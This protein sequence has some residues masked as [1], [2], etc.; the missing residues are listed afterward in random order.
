MR[1]TPRRVDDPPPRRA[2]TAKPVLIPRVMLSRGVFVGAIVFIGLG[3]FVLYSMLRALRA[4]R[5]LVAASHASSVRFV[6]LAMELQAELDER[7]EHDRATLQLYLSLEREHLPDL[8]RTAT[9]AAERCDPAAAKAVATALADFGEQAH[10]HSRAM[11]DALQSQA[12]RAHRRA[13][14]LAQGMLIQARADRERLLK[15]GD[16]QW[17]DADLEGPL[18]ALARRLRKPNATFQLPLPTLQEW[19]AA[20]KEALHEGGAV[21]P[22]LSRRLASLALEAPLPRDDADR[23]EVARAATAHDD[24]TSAFVL[25][26]QRARLHR[27]LPQ[28]LAVL[29]GFEAHQRPV[30][31]VVELI[32]QL[33]AQHVFPMGMLHLQQHEWDQVVGGAAEKA[34]RDP[35]SFDADQ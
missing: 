15:Y 22:G 4:E 1:S 33:R 7:E 8:Q 10:A 14:E 9:A 35:H 26:L 6:R 24:P 11:L 12:G 3:S 31:D 30:W 25:L 2:P 34:G 20:Y 29:T 28:L 21:S 23:T 16:A 17:S 32:E 18:R 19:E 27:H 5:A 13:Q